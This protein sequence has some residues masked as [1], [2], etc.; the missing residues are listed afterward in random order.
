MAENS[1]LLYSLFLRRRVKPTPKFLGVCALLSRRGR[2]NFSLP[3]VILMMSLLVGAG[4]SS[5]ARAGAIAPHKSSAKLQQ[6]ATSPATASQ[7]KPQ[8]LHLQGVLVEGGAECPR[9][10]ASDNTYYTLEGD[11]H[12]F[13][14]GDAVEITGVVPRVSHCMQDTPLQIQTIR[15]AGAKS[16]KTK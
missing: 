11:L 8:V 5:L 7:D 1:P 6:G 10:R 3:L 2:R 12:G 9:F 16:P 14:I 15:A 4:R 13:H